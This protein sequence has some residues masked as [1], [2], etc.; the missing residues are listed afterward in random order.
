[1]DSRPMIHIDHVS[2]KFS[3]NINKAMIYGIKDIAKDLVGIP[4][5]S[6]TLRKYE[7]WAVKD[8]SFMLE[9]G[10][11]IGIVGPNGSGKSTLPHAL[12]N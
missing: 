6:D 3:K 7:F 11:S 1:M 2:K 8:V 4:T 5:H 9:K 12:T 10:H